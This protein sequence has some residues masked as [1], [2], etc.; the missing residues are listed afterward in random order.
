DHL[1]D[2]LFV[3]EGDGKIR[4]FNG[5]YTDYRDWVEEEEQ[6]LAANKKSGKQAVTETAVASPEE[7][8]KP[9]FKEKQ[10]FE[11]L[12]SEIDSLEKKKSEV[13]EEFAKGSADHQR[14]EQLSKEI[15]M[16][17]D[18]IDEK[19]LRWLELSEIIE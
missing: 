9:S 16:I 14:L 2:Q 18:A 17:T 13:T 4:V 8:R 15:K 11:K 1:V 19:T 5:N 6:Q 3:F 10:E 12:Q 7:K